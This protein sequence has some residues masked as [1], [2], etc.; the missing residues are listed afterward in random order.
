VSSSAPASILHAAWP[1]S[2][3]GNDKIPIPVIKPVGFSRL[4]ARLDPDPERAGEE[5]ERLRLTLEKF[6]DWR[7][8]W[9]PEEC[10]DETLDRLARKLEDEVDIHDVRSYAH[11]IARLVLLEWQRRP[12][13]VS[14]A[15]DPRAARLAAPLT[16]DDEDERFQDCFN[17]CLGQLPPESRAL[18]VEYYVAERRAKI[19]NRRRLA[20]SF[21]ITESALRNRMQRVRGRLERCVQA[22]TSAPTTGNTPARPASPERL[23]RFPKRNNA[24]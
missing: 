24:S 6:F 17:R 3:A 19:E 16:I 13:L 1:H 11:G 9:P 10:A 12:A 5:Y 2:P 15:G 7:G 14:L 18:V 22:C 20:R 8:A 21:G 23:S 4:L